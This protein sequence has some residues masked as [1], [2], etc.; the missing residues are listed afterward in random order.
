MGPYID[1]RQLE[2]VLVMAEELN[3]RKAAERLK[4]HQSTVSKGIKQFEK[5]QELT[6]FVR[7]GKRIADLTPEGGRFLEH[8]RPAFH[9]FQSEAA[10]AS[11]IAEL[12]LRKSAGTFMLGYSP[13]VSAEMLNEVRFVRSAR[14]RALRL[15][16]RQLKPSE[17]FSFV[18][19][20]VLQA[21][22]T[23]AF[24][25]RHRLEQIPVGGEPI[26]AVYPRRPGTRAG[27]GIDLEALR[28]QQLYLLS[29]DRE[30]PELREY[31]VSE[32]TRRGFTPKIA[33]ETDSA[34][35]AFDLLL[36][37]GGA[38]IMPECMYVGAPADLHCSRI[39]DLEETQLVLTYRRGTDM[40]TEK[41]IREIARSLRDGRIER[42][43]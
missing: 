7:D 4:G 30:Q 24:P 14:F 29:S 22:L 9:V 10:R 38:A 34:R 25:Q 27:V 33:E 18:R 5:E 11:E 20:G 42:T 17:I 41:I 8:I 36:D 16:V 13:L 15:Q 3:T 1:P 31:L 26:C 35:Q 40:R 37:R 6:A 2:I 12:I 19:S 43:G 21:G 39:A 23:Y 32:C 28:S